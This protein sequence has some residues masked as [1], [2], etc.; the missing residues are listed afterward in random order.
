MRRISLLLAAMISVL[1]ATA[2]A[3]DS[4]A[5]PV[6]TA[7]PQEQISQAAKLEDLPDARAAIA[8]LNALKTLKARFIQTDNEGKQLSGDFYLK[9]PGRMRFQYDAPVKDFVVADGMFVYYY[10]GKMKQQSAAPI[11]KS[12][13]NF[14]LRKDINLKDGL[15]L[16]G[17]RRED[18][19]LYLTLT[20][21]QD[22]LAGSLILAF[23][24]DGKGGITQLDKWRVVDA[25]GAITEVA[26]FNAVTGISLDSE[27]FHYYDPERGTGTNQ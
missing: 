19:T 11:S 7:S 4:A 25:T 18:G 26:L 9:R 27:L 13:A 23:K 15:R 16:D 24:T 22:P 20:Q 3:A 5:A 8:Y 6:Q 14:F 17:V 12:L 2:R 10:D 21:A 1:P